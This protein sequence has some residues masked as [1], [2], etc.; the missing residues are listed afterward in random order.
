MGAGRESR[1]E[2]DAM[3]VEIVYALVSGA[4]IAVAVTVVAVAVTLPVTPHGVALGGLVGLAHIVRV[5]RRFDR[6]RRL[7][8]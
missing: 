4:L 5:L 3:T 7:G 8:R 6:E 2:K 1:A